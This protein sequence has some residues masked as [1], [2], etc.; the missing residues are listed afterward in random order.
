MN[1]E[2]TN[3]INAAEELKG[4]NVMVTFKDG[5]AQN[6]TLKS[7]KFTDKSFDVF[8]ELAD[9]ADESIL[10]NLEKVASIQATQHK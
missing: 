6:G 1:Q 9:E 7:T 2:I 3:L 4:Q 5:Q 8:I 10:F